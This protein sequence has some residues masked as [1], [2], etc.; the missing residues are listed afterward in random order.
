MIFGCLVII[1]RVD[2]LALVARAARGQ[3][4]AVIRYGFSVFRYMNTAS[5]ELD[6]AFSI[7]EK[8]SVS[9]LVSDPSVARLVSEGLKHYG[10]LRGFCG[11]RTSL[12]QLGPYL[13]LSLSLSLS[14]SRVTHRKSQGDPGCLVAASPLQADSSGRAARPA[15][16]TC[17]KNSL[18]VSACVVSIHRK[19]VYIKNASHIFSEVHVTFQSRKVASK[20]RSL[21]AFIRQRRVA[22]L[23]TTRAGTRWTQQTG[24]SSRLFLQRSV[25]P[26]PRVSGR[27]PAVLVHRVLPPGCLHLTGTRHAKDELI[28]DN[29]SILRTDWV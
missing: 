11:R 29:W 14:R 1:D 15:C 4:R 12:L 2:R 19:G 16:S 27:G 13:T 28:H 21:G 23:V 26:S 5:V 9:L 24:R 3:L 22:C 6:A 20:H 10:R 18:A 8:L 25:L 17:E 7:D